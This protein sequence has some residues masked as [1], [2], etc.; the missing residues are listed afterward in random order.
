MELIV[1]RRDPR[2]WII[3]R[4]ADGGRWDEVVV[5]RGTAA[6]LGNE[7]VIRLFMG[8]IFCN[9]KSSALPNVS[10]SISPSSEQDSSERILLNFGSGANL[11]K[12]M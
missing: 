5:L 4:R 6:C 3:A 1:V 8:S 9:V 12:L 11:S 10:V 2:R 7:L